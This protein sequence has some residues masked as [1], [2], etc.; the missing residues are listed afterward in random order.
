MKETQP[1]YSIGDYFY[2]DGKEGVVFWV[3]HNGFS[4][5]IVHLEGTQGDWLNFDRRVWPDPNDRESFLYFCGYTQDGMKNQ[6]LIMSEVDWQEKFPAFAWCASLGPGWYFPA[7]SEMA[8]IIENY[9]KINKTLCLF[10]WEHL[11]LHN[12]IH[13]YLDSTFGPRTFSRNFHYMTY[14]DYYYDPGVYCNYIRAVS[15]FSHLDMLED[16]EEWMRSNYK[17]KHSQ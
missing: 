3:D 6:L 11:C 12:D 15:V 4:G 8:Q 10:N 7:Y 13:V 1:P 14:N 16:Q 17:I 2:E 5:K 9:A